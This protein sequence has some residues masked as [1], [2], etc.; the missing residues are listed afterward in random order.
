MSEERFDELEEDLEVIKKKEK[1]Q[2]R[3]FVER[4]VEAMLGGNID[5]TSI[6]RLYNDEKC[7]Y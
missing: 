7:M 5:N 3:D 4:L 6:T 2:V 1:E